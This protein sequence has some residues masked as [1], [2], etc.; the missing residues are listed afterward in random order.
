MGYYVSELAG[1]PLLALIVDVL[2][3]RTGHFCM[4]SD[5]LRFP[6]AVRNAAKADSE[7]A[8][9]K[10]IEGLASIRND[11]ERESE[12]A[13]EQRAEQEPHSIS[14]QL[15]FSD[16]FLLA[17]T[18]NGS[19]EA[20]GLLFRRYRHVVRSVARR[21]LRDET[22]AEDLCQEVFLYL[23]Q[24]AKLFDAGKGTASSWIVQM[25]AS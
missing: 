23:F 8:P 20:V 4:S 25:V 19:K 17:E 16:E 2:I 7:V 1:C 18:A 3:D 24:K 12:D 11:F 14:S 10:S 22:E 15:D 21:I 6:E 13:K 9:S 5:A